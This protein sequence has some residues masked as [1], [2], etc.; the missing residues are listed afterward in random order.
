MM[1]KLPE[2]HDIQQ[3]RQAYRVLQGCGSPHC[4]GDDRL[5]ALILHETQDA[6]REQLADHL[7]RCRRCTDLYRTLLR[8]HHDLM[9]TLPGAGKSGSA[10]TDGTGEGAEQL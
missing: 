6:E 1:E 3:W 4:P 2:N 9:G 5:I 8:I 10:T 7:V